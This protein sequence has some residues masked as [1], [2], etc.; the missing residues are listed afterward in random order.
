MTARPYWSTTDGP[1]GHR[2]VATA[3]EFGADPSDGKWIVYCHTHGTIIN[4]SSRNDARATSTSEFC[5][6]CADANPQLLRRDAYALLDYFRRNANQFERPDE[7]I[8]WAARRFGQYHGD[9]AVWA[10][11]SI[12]TYFRHCEQPT[13]SPADIRRITL[14]A[15]S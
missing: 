11:E 14:R 1:L 8:Y 15:A 2:T 6:E 10:A 5:E 9:N 4:T 3:E 12:V 13:R 7:W